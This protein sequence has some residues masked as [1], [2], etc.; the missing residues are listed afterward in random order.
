[1]AMERMLGGLSTRHYRTGLEP[2][3]EAVEESSRSTSK[4]A[5]SRK[6]VAMTETA[7]T[8]RAAGPG[9]GYNQAEHGRARWRQGAGRRGQGGPRQAGHRSLP[10]AQAEERPRPPAR[11]HARPGGDADAEGLPRGLRARGRGAADR[12]GQGAGQDPPGRR[13]EPA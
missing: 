11:E 6:F 7:L 1:M 13:R 4:S 5:V 10:A 9:P 8:D 2:V 3:G 12:A